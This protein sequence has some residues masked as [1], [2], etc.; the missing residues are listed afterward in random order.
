LQQTEEALGTQIR[1]RLFLIDSISASRQR[2]IV[3]RD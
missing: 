2:Q 3:E 1:H